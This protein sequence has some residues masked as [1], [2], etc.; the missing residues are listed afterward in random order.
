MLALTYDEREATD[1][2]SQGST[3]ILSSATNFAKWM[4]SYLRPYG[5]EGNLVD[6]QYDNQLEDPWYSV[7]KTPEKTQ[8][9]SNVAGP[10][11]NITPVKNLTINSINGLE[12]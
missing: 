4:P 12:G 9:T 1:D 11:M 2:P 8:N 10:T 7:S 3:V 6:P 5:S